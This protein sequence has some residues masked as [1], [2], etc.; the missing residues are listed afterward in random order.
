MGKADPMTEP[1]RPFSLEPGGGR[2]LPTPVG[3]QV[4]FKVRGDD[5][6]GRVSLCEF[7][8]PAGAGPRRHVHEEAEECIYVLRGEIRVELGDEAHE[9]PTGSCVFI[10]RGLTHCFQNTGSESA[11]LLAVY[12]PAGIEAFFESFAADKEGIVPPPD[13]PPQRD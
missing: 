2:A 8:V 12:T 5:S 7:E 3:G 9:A 13:S 4:T 6:S 1:G 10:P 11:S